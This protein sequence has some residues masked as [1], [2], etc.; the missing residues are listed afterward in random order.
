VREA[1]RTPLLPPNTSLIFAT[2]STQSPF[3]L[4]EK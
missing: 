1:L 4:C 2:C 3:W